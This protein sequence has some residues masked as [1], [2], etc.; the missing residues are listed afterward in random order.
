MPFSAPFKGCREKVSRLKCAL[1]IIEITR[2]A[3]VLH[4]WTMARAS[5][6]QGA[7]STTL[8][9]N[10]DLRRAV[11]PCG[12][13]HQIA[14]DSL[15]LVVLGRVDTG[16]AGGH[17]FLRILGRDD[18]ANHDRDLADALLAHAAQD[19]LDQRHVRAGE[20]GEADDVDAL[21]E[22]GV[23]DTGG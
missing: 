22:R 6:V 18:A 21:L 3:Y 13:I 8:L 7:A 1:A 9:A 5:A 4:A 15:D 23:G 19:L 20:D 10:R 12:N 14:H 2:L 11:I 16:D 17:E